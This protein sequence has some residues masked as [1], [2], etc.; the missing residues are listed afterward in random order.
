MTEVLLNVNNKENKV[1]FF[2]YKNLLVTF[3]SV[4]G[5]SFLS[6]MFLALVA[7]IYGEEAVK[8][9]T[10][11]Y[12]ILVIDAIVTML[13]VLFYKPARNFITDIWN[14]SVLKLPKTYGYILL[15]FIVIFISQYATLS[16]LGFESAEQQR[17]QLGV[18]SL[19]NSVIQ[20]IIYIFSIA[21]ITPI[22]EELM[23]RGIL[24]RFLEQRHNFIVGILVSS[25]VFGLSHGG[26]PITAT[27]MGIVF[28]ILYKKTNSILPSI[29]LHVIWNLI[30]SIITI[31]SY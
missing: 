11:G 8:N 20:N 19:Q 30:V 3:L 16:L 9:I 4:L 2:S 7:G 12:Y 22:K 13:V 29:I 25:L 5:F 18:A 31:L 6:G 15:G 28:V 10:Q 17:N 21:F 27:I 26:L 1:S 14:V 23:Y 24:Y